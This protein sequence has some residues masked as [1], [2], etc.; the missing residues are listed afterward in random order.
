MNCETGWFEWLDL[1]YTRSK[2]LWNPENSDGAV[3]AN[4][5]TQSRCWWP[6]DSFGTLHLI[7]T[8]K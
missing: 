6:F 4:P 2:I 5:I 8:D 7:D 3:K 1:V